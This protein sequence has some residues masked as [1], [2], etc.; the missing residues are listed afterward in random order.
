MGRRRPPRMSGLDA[1][2]HTS[3]PESYR[4]SAKG[5]SRIGKTTY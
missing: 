1:T 3:N 5:S 2:H 4:A